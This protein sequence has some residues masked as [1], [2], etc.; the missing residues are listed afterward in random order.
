MSD[1]SFY[2]INNAPGIIF[3][4]KSRGRR[5][6]LIPQ[7]LGTKYLPYGSPKVDN[8]TIGPFK[9]LTMPYEDSAQ[10]LTGLCSINLFGGSDETVLRTSFA[11]LLTAVSKMESPA[12]SGNYTVP[13]FDSPS[14]VVNKDIKFTTTMSSDEVFPVITTGPIQIR[15][16]EVHLESAF[17]YD[18]LSKAQMDPGNT[19]SLHLARFKPKSQSLCTIIEVGYPGFGKFHD[20]FYFWLCV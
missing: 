13:I 8:S 3:H 15:E 7:F 14:H 9:A 16:H 20:K 5:I 19:N 18:T 2:N 4:F 17:S 1:L 10:Y 11:K 12:G 6:V